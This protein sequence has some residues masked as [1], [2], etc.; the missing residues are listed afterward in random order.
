MIDNRKIRADS[1]LSQL[2]AE[3]QDDVITHCESIKLEDGVAWLKATF[4]LTLSEM[5]LSRWLR[6]HRALRSV[7]ARL[8]QIQDAR[9]QAT[10]IGKVVGAATDITD[11]N[12]VL[13][14]QAVFEELLKPPSERDEVK[15]SHYMALGIKVNEQNLKTRAGN[16]A[17]QRFHFD[18]GRKALAFASQL[19]R[20]N[21]SGVDERAKIEEAMVLLFGKPLTVEV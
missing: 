20:I 13:I 12:V 10:L 3:Q 9:D 1:R 14:A 16:L 6:K 8:Q 7:A 2:T 21:E 5:G 17:Y 15:L 18:V 11:A 19:Q 4:N